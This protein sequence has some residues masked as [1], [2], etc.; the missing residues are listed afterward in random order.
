MWYGGGVEEARS[1]LDEVSFPGDGEEGGRMLF[2]IAVAN[3][4]SDC[5][6]VRVVEVVLFSRI[7]SVG[8]GVS[9]SRDVRGAGCLIGRL[10]HLLG[11]GVIFAVSVAAETGVLEGVFSFGRVDVG[12]RRS[13]EV[14]SLSF[15]DFGVGRWTGEGL[16]G[17]V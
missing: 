8:D 3:V 17:E 7:G 11:I 2:F 10:S 9:F 14:D 1:S 16:I 5:K 15:G 6:E 13:V 4:L 12:L